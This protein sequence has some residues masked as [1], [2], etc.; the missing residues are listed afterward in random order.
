MGEAAEGAVA[1][2]GGALLVRAPREPELDP[3]PTLASAAGAASMTESATS[4]ASLAN[5]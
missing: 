2:G 1:V 4:A 3:P 5:E